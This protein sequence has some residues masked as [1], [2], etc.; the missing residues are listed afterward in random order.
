M[1]GA[2]ILKLSRL[3]R[4]GHRKCLACTHPRLK[5]DFT[6]DGPHRLRSSIDF[7]EEMTSFNGM[8]H[9]GVLALL[10]DEAMT[11]ALMAEGHYG[12]TAELNLR[13]RRPVRVERTAYI[14]VTVDS[15]YNQLYKLNAV[16][17][18]QGE[19]CTSAEGRFIKQIC[20]DG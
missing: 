2:S 15:S 14:S 12:A 13:Y 8:V 6:M 5:L 18:Q 19:I 17:K 3:R 20:E 11:C 4:L 7:T 16:V 9:G 1:I 10:I